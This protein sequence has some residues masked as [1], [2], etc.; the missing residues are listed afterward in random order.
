MHQSTTFHYRYFEFSKKLKSDPP[1]CTNIYILKVAEN[2]TRERDAKITNLAEIKAV[3]GLLYL[4][5]VLRSSHLR[6]SDLWET[7]RT[8]VEA[9][10]DSQCP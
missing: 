9:L 7:E 6:L 2:Y 5:G 8:G 10:L 3:I 4:G 1:Y